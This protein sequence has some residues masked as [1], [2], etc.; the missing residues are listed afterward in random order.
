MNLFLVVMHIFIMFFGTFQLKTWTGI[1][2]LNK[3]T[4]NELPMT[5]D[6]IFFWRRNEIK[7]QNKGQLI[8]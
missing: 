7:Y 1:W 5:R 2:I 8:V 6:I 4:G 3:C